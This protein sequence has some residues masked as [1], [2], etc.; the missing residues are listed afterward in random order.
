M[1]DHSTTRQHPRPLVDLTCPVCHRTFTRKPSD[2]AQSKTR[3]CSI[4]CKAVGQSVPKASPA[5]RFWRHVRKSE[6]GCWLWEG[7]HLKKGYGR[8][9]IVARKQVATAHRFSWELH[10]GTI[11]DGMDVCHRC[12]NPRCVRP[13]HL[14]LATPAKN[15][16]DWIRDTGG[17]LG[18]RHHGTHLTES[19]VLAIRAR[20]ARGER[21]S[22]LASE[23]GLSKAAVSKMILRKSWKHIP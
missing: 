12:N 13:D 18:S 11:P 19:E 8:L 2:I 7:A 14:Y 17:K 16:R 3:Y 10:Y 9:T 23:F 15:T 4:A 20:A 21:G 5:E 1:H 22:D 6:D